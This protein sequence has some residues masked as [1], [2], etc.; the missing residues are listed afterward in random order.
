MYKFATQ[1][2]PE[3]IA[4]RK[5]LIVDGIDTGYVEEEWYTRQEALPC[6]WNDECHRMLEQRA[7]VGN[8]LVKY[9]LQCD[10]QIPEHGCI[11][12]IEENGTIKKH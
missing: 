10:K 7:I 9:C 3:F 11:H 2:E 6:W 5:K 8:S 12:N 1:K 4:S